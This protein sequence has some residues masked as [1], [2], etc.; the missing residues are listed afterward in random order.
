MTMKVLVAT[1]IGGT[2]TDLIA[3]DPD[4]RRV[5]V[6]KVPTSPD[7]ATGVVD[8]LGTSDVDP[9]AV[10]QLRH[11]S[12]VAINAVLEERGAP[13]ALV[14]TEGFADV[15]A[16]GRGNR[17]EPFRLDAPG[18]RV[19]VPAEH[20]LE[21]A[22]RIRHDGSVERPLEDVEGL[23][24][25]LPAAEVDAVAVCLL[26]SYA[27]P[28]HER[29]LTARLR[30]AH[31]DVFVVASH[32]VCREAREFERTSTTVLHSYVGP[33]VTS[34]LSQLTELLRDQGVAAR[35]LVMQS[36]GGL[37]REEDVAKRPALVM[38]SGPAS[39]VMGVAA[40]TGALARPHAIAFDMGGTTAKAALL[41]DGTP[42]FLQHYA[43]GGYE[44]GLPL[45][46]PVLDIHE[47]GAGG[48]SIAWR[49]AAGALHVGP[50]S[51]GSTPGPICYGRGGTVPTVCDADLVLGRLS[52]DDA[53]GGTVTLDL[54]AAREGIEAHIARPLGATLERAAEGIVEIANTVM[55]QAIRK[56]S[57][58]R[59]KDPRAYDLVAYGGAGPMHATD[60]AR[61]LG[62]R[63]VVVPPSPGVFSAFGMLH[64]PLRTDLNQTVDLPLEQVALDTIA[65]QARA[66]LGE[67]SAAEDGPR[68]QG[69][70]LG[71][72][73]EGQE[74]TQ[75]VTVE[76][77]THEA[78]LASFEERYRSRYGYVLDDA[79]VEVTTIGVW[80]EIAE[81][82]PPWDKLAP[83]G[84]GPA[85][86]DGAA[87]RLHWP[88]VGW[89]DGTKHWRSRLFAGST[90]PGPALIVEETSACVLGP[91][92][93]AT[94]G[95]LGE[96]R[97]RIG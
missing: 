52:A 41:E 30:R 2:F 22:E 91:D 14:T 7:Y 56:V 4:A 25:R 81:L 13:V 65:A 88:G 46:A 92:D 70:W 40:L 82:T 79:R 16:M 76:D 27:N 59:G 38:E 20:R 43:I 5:H 35:M 19:L 33:I 74:H 12:T 15:L 51:A 44:Q 66:L 69:V 71:L 11:G 83:A 34:Y 75:R 84:A 1:D 95:E 8:V 77:W 21:A 61:M 9:G 31:P 29:E 57:I 85:W 39:G 73:Y 50:R 17:P 58:E 37:M 90:V 63:T 49:D 97:I 55:A 96:L 36:N 78:I 28:E 86:H 42:G 60:V 23:L 24:A 32:E 67:I 62:I 47:V 3:W 18:H 10:G 26:H 87:H 68:R 54:D 93:T 64:T 80:E 72:R 89:V 53:L 48:G 6:A 45:L 94:V